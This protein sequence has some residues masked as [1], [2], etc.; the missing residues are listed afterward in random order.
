MGPRS[1]VAFFP[2]FRFKSGLTVRPKLMRARVPFRPE[3]YCIV[4]GRAKRR[5]GPDPVRFAGR[6]RIG[7]VERINMSVGA[8]NGSD[9]R[10]WG[11]SRKVNFFDYFNE[12]ELGDK[13][14]LDSNAYFRCFE[15]KGGDIFNA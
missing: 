6:N 5:T 8:V 11:R 1:G 10:L 13:M 12:V 3:G 9:R 14:R 4:Y 2:G 7:K 15:W